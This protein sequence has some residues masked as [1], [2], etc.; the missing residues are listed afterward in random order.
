MWIF[1]IRQNLALT[2]RTEEKEKTTQTTPVIFLVVKEKCVWKQKQ[3][4]NVEDPWDWI[5]KIP[6][7]ILYTKGTKFVRVRFFLDRHLGGWTSNLVTSSL[8]TAHCRVYELFFAALLLQHL[9]L[10][11]LHSSPVMYNLTTA[12]PLDTR[13]VRS[14]TALVCRAARI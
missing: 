4:L 10:L 8:T 5:L 3:L 12:E 6:R 11:I 14:T 9:K 7:I 1:P 13:Y 2:V